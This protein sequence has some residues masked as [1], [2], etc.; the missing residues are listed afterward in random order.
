MHTRASCR[1][2]A[3]QAND[4]RIDVVYGRYN[5]LANWAEYRYV[6]HVDGIS[7][8]CRLEKLLATGPLLLK[9]ESGYRWEG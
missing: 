9:E 6:A 4:S 3:K 5:G 7:C 1:D 2:W 8:S